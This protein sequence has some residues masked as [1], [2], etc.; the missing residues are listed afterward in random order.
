MND[1]AKQIENELNNELMHNVRTVGGAVLM[2]QEAV[3]NGTAGLPG[4][5]YDTHKAQSNWFV[6]IDGESGRVT[7]DTDKANLYFA[8]SEV[9]TA[10]GRKTP[11][12]YFSL[13]NN[14]PYIRHL[15]FGLY[16]NPPKTK[17][18]RTVNGFSTQAPQGMFRLAVEK[19]DAILK[20]AGKKK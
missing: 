10:L 6:E 7:E 1:F 12:R 15:E 14:L 2:L 19:W 16:P 9:V 13:F 3:V 11:P 4:T 20:K 5:P 18:G 17:T 8:Q